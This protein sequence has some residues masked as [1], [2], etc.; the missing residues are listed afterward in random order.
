MTAF[1]RVSGSGRENGW[2]VEIRS[3]NHRF[4]EFSVKLP[5]DF[6]AFEEQIR[7][8]VRS[9][10]SRGKI[11]VAIV[12]HE[13]V[14]SGREL[15][16][17]DEEAVRN[18]R[19][20]FSRLNK[21]HHIRGEVTVGEMMTLP[22]ILKLEKPKRSAE[23][24]WPVV[25]RLLKRTIDQTVSMKEKE[26]R[27]IMKDVLARLR[28]IRAAVQKMEKEAYKRSVYYFGKLKTRVGELLEREFQDKDRLY[29]EVAFLA[30]K[31]DA[32]EEVNRM[33]SHL[34][35]F[36]D[37]VTRCRT[38]IGRELDFLCQEMNREIN[39]LGVKAQ[40]F[41]ISQQVVFVKSEI[42]KIR[43]QIQNIE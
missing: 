11:N 4:F 20:L 2:A 6:F 43:E 30:E 24:I 39:T 22:G 21:K 23:E 13:A 36:Q 16:T 34:A 17:L 18:Y 8:L 12:Q 41:E 15:F 40:F 38:E 14:K 32:T 29:R 35:L 37:R 7:D 42:E 25:E 19:H 31:S 1:A 9:R 33:K 5:P 26:G 10:I 28:N 27:Q 3:I